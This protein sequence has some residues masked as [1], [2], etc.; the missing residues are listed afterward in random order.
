MHSRQQAILNKD[1]AIRLNKAWGVGA[2]QARYS[3]DG[4]WY[5]TLVRFPAALFDSNGYVYFATESEYQAAPMS[6]GKQIS[7]PKPGIS[8]MPGYIHRGNSE[9]LDGRDTDVRFA[10]ESD[11]EG[12]K[13]EVLCLSRKRSRT[14]RDLAFKKAGGVCCVCDRDFSKLLDG[15]GVR[16]LQVHHRKQLSARVAPSVT[17]VADLA[18]VCA[19]C[20]MLLHLDSE[21]AL[22]V[23]ELRSMLQSS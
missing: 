15:R 19:N 21:Q 3:E 4:H 12:T 23:D 13:T 17:M 16:V 9:A 22:D 2:V 8:A 6:I 20:H 11:I 18:V 7:V 10:T 1:K 5:A 14:L